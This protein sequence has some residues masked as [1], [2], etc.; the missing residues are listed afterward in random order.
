MVKLKILLTSQNRVHHYLR[1]LNHTN[2][3]IKFTAFIY[4]INIIG[5]Q[6]LLVAANSNFTFT[7]GVDQFLVFINLHDVQ[8]VLFT[9][10]IRYD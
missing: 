6:Q 9:L 4:Y 10:V 8:S 7:G 5:E 2:V 1:L 3:I